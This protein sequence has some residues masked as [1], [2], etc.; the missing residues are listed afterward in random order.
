MIGVREDRDSNE[1]KIGEVIPGMPAASAGIEVGDVIVKF[2][3]EPVPDFDAL[4]ELVGKTR[5]GQMVVVELR[6]NGQTIQL[7]LTVGKAPQE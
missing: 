6:R 5:P 2:N 3:G 1:A 4:V 7:K